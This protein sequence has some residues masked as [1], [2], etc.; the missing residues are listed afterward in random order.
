MKQ[1]HRK[2]HTGP[3]LAA[4]QETLQDPFMDVSEADTD[5]IEITPESQQFQSVLDKCNQRDFFSSPTALTLD[6]EEVVGL[7]EHDLVL[8]TDARVEQTSKSAS[9]ESVPN[10][11]RNQI[12]IGN[13]LAAA[14]IL[15]KQAAYQTTGMPP[16]ILP[17]A[18]IML[19]LYL[20]R[21]VM[22]SGLSQQNYLS[23][24]LLILYPFAEKSETDWAPLPCTVSGF[25]SRF[26]NV[27]N[28]NSLVSILP[29]P[30]PETLLDGHGYTP[31]RTILEHVFMIETFDTTDSIDPKW[32]SLASSNKFHSFLCNII[33]KRSDLPNESAVRPMAVG[34]IIWTDG[35]DPS[36]GCKSNRTPMHTGTISLLIVDVNSKHVVG[37]CTY[38]NMGGP[39]KIDHEPVFRRL[40]EDVV[41]FEENDGNRK[42]A[43]RHHLCDV[44][45]YL[46]VMFVV[47]DQPERRM[48]SGL[49]GGGSK[50][51]PLF[52][53][54][55]DFLKLRLPF[56]ACT[57]CG[58]LLQEYLEKRDWR[59]P[60]M[61]VRCEHCLGW[62]LKRLTEATYHS[63][64]FS[65]PGHAPSIDDT[66][67]IIVPPGIELFNGPGRLSSRLL[68]AAWSH[69]ID[70]FVH[71]CRWVES[72]V[73]LYL[74]QLCINEATVSGFVDACRRHIFQKEM[75]DNPGSYTADQISQFEQDRAIDPTSYH[76]PLAPAMWSLGDIDD[77]PEGI[78]HLSMG[79]QKA[80][81]KFIILWAT[82]HSLGATL[83]RRLAENLRSIQDLHVAYC[84]C[85]PYKDE[86][87]GG[88]TAEGYRAMTMASLHIYRALLEE[89]LQPKPPRGPNPKPPNE[90]TRQDNVNWMYVRGFECTSKIHLPE[91]REMVRRYMAEKPEPKI[92][93]SPRSQI[94]TTEIRDLVWRMYNMF[95]AIFCTDMEGRNAQHRATASVM[96][97]LTLIEQLDVKL[98]PQRR[99]PIWIAKFNFLGLLRVCESFVPFRHVKNLYE[100][101]EIG[102]AIVKQLRPFVAKGVHRRWATNLLLAHYRNRTLDTLID[103]LEDNG[104]KQKGCLLGILIEASKFKRYST[105]AEI[106][107]LMANGR[108]IPVLVYGSPI[109]WKV[110][111]IIVFQKHWY[112]KEIVFQKSVE[113]KVDD[114]YGLTYHTVISPALEPC[115]GKV[116]GYINQSLGS[117]N[118]PFWDYALMFADLVGTIH[119]FRYAIVRSGWEHLSVN[120]EWSTHD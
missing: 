81:F 85:R 21:L 84:P 1:H 22:S 94:A 26:L 68:T 74:G 91:T 62:S 59:L 102:E 44:E 118:L 96:R 13:T 29:I 106:T 45:V 31:L 42:F 10:N 73:K 66:R 115:F 90:W 79:I 24:L 23:K 117:D 47:Q 78:M 104:K 109:K 108:P 57:E 33:G 49:L 39:G 58:I 83:Q 40:K 6:G 34:L 36:T 70:E 98:T 92:I 65:L 111:A 60:P 107:H 64:S 95:R 112:F 71:T 120:N 103:S 41:A 37:V 48:A 52:G 97:F 114:K 28:S 50:I 35:W 110:G 51:H 17:I 15:V 89:E 32:H 100:G 46:Q 3:V 53:M 11:F 77:K 14:S 5:A 20:A 19:F 2:C 76:L 9:L 72:D 56:V 82:E 116:G 101:G 86:K 99:K 7:E 87:F 38:P 75:E 93:R 55:C 105:T 88:F 63:S 4:H 69:C 25:R 16:S 30:V 67:P 61:V 27:S 18:N 113:S 119:Q 43:S 8:E 54:S 12:A 80:V